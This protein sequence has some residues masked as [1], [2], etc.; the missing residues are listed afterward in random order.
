MISGREENEVN[1]CHSKGRME[2]ETKEK[3]NALAKSINGREPVSILEPIV[4]WNVL[5]L[6]KETETIVK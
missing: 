1:M 4:N 2:S 3:S 5:G 6:H